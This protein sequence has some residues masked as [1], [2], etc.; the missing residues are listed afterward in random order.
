MINSFI[1]EVLF[2]LAWCRMNVPNYRQNDGL[3]ES[4]SKVLSMLKVYRQR[5]LI[6]L[7]TG[8]VNQKLQALLFWKFYSCYH[9]VRW[10]SRI[11]DKMTEFWKVVLDFSQCQK[12]IDK[13]YWLSWTLVTQLRNYNLF[14]FGSFTEFDMMSEERPGLSRKSQISGKLF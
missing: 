6:I 12:Y 8:H 14:Y 13:G 3:L 1:W 10:T 2:M 11:I 7:A 5:F 9:D 4:C